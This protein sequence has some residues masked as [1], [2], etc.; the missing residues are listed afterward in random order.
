MPCQFGILTPDLWV[1]PLCSKGKYFQKWANDLGAQAPSLLSEALH[2]FDGICF[3]QVF[4]RSVAQMWSETNTTMGRL[5]LNQTLSGGAHQPLKRADAHCN[6]YF[7]LSEQLADPVPR[8][9]F[10]AQLYPALVQL[11]TRIYPWNNF[12]IYQHLI[13][14]FLLRR[15][16]L[17]KWAHELDGLLKDCSWFLGRDF[18]GVC[19]SAPHCFPSQ[20]CSC[21]WRG[22]L[23]PPL[24]RAHL[25]T[26]VNPPAGWG[27]FCS[28][29]LAGM[30][31]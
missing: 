1:S 13:A 15:T 6:T 4:N 2:P 23:Y 9:Q 29:T 26:E 31:Q 7:A 10:T 24:L 20:V 14:T 19:F 8:F 27:A 12:I 21:S 25:T 5:N 11:S 3:T 28:H 30:E 22:C 16:V 18:Y 17:Q